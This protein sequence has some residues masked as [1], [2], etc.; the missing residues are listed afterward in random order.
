MLCKIAALL[1]VAVPIVVLAVYRFVPP[2]VTPLMLMRSAAGAPIRQHWV[3]LSRIS[4]WLLRAVVASEDAR[5]CSH[6]GFDFEEIG[7]ALERFRAGGRLRGASTISQQTAKNILLWPG[8][9]FLRKGIEA[10][11]T[12]LLELGWPKSR[13]AEVYLNVIE[14]GEGIY[15]A[16]PAAEAHF[17]KPAAALTRRDAA[18][19]AAILPNPRR[20]SVERPTAYVLERAATIEARMM[21]VEIPGTASCR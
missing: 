18:L 11:I 21:Q 19:L 2:P 4:P 9:G 10:Y 17:G 7:A 15:G 1:V 8:G 14:W 12:G 6:H 16:E 3:P 20:F 13:I 5:F